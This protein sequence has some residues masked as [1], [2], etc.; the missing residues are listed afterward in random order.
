[1]TA[2]MTASVSPYHFGDFR[3]EVAVPRLVKLASDATWCNMAAVA[4]NPSDDA[5]SW[6]C[7]EA[8]GI[9]KECHE[10]HRVHP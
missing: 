3:I 8:S 4:S 2:T 9:R 7:V 6:R 1:M 5:G 10:M